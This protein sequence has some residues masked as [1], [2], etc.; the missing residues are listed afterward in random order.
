MID[1]FETFGCICDRPRSGRSLFSE[2]EI[3]RVESELKDQQSASSLSV[4][5][6]RNIAKRLEMASSSVHKILR[7]HLQLKPYHLKHLQ[8]LNDNDLNE[9]YQFA[10]WF[11]DACSRCP[12]I[13]IKTKKNIPRTKPHFFNRIHVG[14]SENV[15]IKKI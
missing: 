13:K 12:Q 7:L 6:C 3:E 9:R 10:H 4:T 5:S 14:V 15:N 1:K 2:E 11:L 8:A